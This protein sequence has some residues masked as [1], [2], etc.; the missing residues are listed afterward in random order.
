MFNTAGSEAATTIPWFGYGALVLELLSYAGQMVYLPRISHKYGPVTLTAMYYTVA[1][2]AT[3]ATLI[4]REHDHLDQV[5]VAAG[6]TA[7]SWNVYML[8]A[9]SLPLHRQPGSHV[10]GY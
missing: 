1:T 7:K 4:A 10:S 2:A 5:R 8:Q 3:S 6:F 9:A